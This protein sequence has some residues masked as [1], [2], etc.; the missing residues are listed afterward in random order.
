MRIQVVD[1]FTDRPF[2]GNPAGV[3][4]LDSDAWPHPDW[5]DEA[6]LRQVAAEMRHSETAFARP[7]ADRTDADWALRWFTPTVEVN[8]CGHAT[9]ATAHALRSRDGA[10]TVRF[11]TRSG[12]LT[13]RS[14]E[15]GTVTMDFPTAE[16]FALPAPDTVAE[17]LGTT[18][19]ATCGSGVLGELRTLVALLPDEATVRALAPDLAAVA[20]LAGTDRIG[21]VIVTAAA[22]DPAAGYDFVSRFFAPAIGVPEDPVTGAAHTVLAP[23]WSQRLGRDQL[24]GWQASTRGGLVR[25]TLRGDRVDLTGHAVTVLDAT[26]HHPPPPPA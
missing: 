14:H 5:P 11:A 19:A 4:L 15:D 2:A 24:T 17:A 12:V 22:A 10:G 16:L 26:W 23:Y 9:L 20:G 21:A 6:W 8:L 3:C 18:P 7:L 1:A 13:T 25:T